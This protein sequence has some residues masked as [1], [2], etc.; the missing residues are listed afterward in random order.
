MAT[1]Q[2]YL[3]KV[4]LFTQGSTKLTVSKA[5][6]DEYGVTAAELASLTPLL[7]SVRAASV[8]AQTAEAQQTEATTQVQ[9]CLK[10]VKGSAS[11]LRTSL[12]N[13]FKRTHPLF[14]QLGLL[15]KAPTKQEEYIGYVDQIFMLGEQLD[16]PN[17]AALAKLKWDKA[18]FTAC[19]AQVAELRAANMAQE[20]AKGEYEVAIKSLYDGFDALDEIYRPLAKNARSAFR[21]NPGE[22]EAL[23]LKSGIPAKPRRPV[24]T[25]ARKPVQA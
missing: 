22:L 18:R 11:K 25:Q 24:P 4:S 8:R 7:D 9:G 3:E 5:L 17:A 6:A 10:A 23:G 16:G 2:G 20:A 15:D 21:D 14:R 1:Q 12:N 13:N 19:T